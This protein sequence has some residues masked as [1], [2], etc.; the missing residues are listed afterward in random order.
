[1]KRDDSGFDRL[2]WELCR[3]G[4]TPKVRSRRLMMIIEAHFHRNPEAPNLAE[5]ASHWISA[6]ADEFDP[7]ALELL[8]AKYP[9]P[10]RLRI[11]P[12]YSDWNSFENPG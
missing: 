5:Y 11:Q 8:A 4:S 7:E 12:G 2:G 3:N 9:L 1:M 6:S 10:D